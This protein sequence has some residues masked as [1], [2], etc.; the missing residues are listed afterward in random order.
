[1]EPDVDRVEDHLPLKDPRTSGSA[2]IGG[3]LYVFGGGAPWFW[4]WFKG[5]LIKRKVMRLGETWRRLAS[6]SGR[7]VRCGLGG[8]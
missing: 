2:L 5:K 3:V 7:T 4:A 8:D 1:M 6:S